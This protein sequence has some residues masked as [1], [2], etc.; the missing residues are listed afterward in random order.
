ME[1]S[2]DLR[3][4]GVQVKDAP[5]REHRDGACFRHV[6]ANAEKRADDQQKSRPSN[7]SPSII[8]LQ[9]SGRCRGLE[10]VAQ[11][12]VGTVVISGTCAPT[13]SKAGCRAPVHYSCYTRSTRVVKAE[14]GVLFINITASSPR[15]FGILARLALHRASR[16]QP[17][18]ST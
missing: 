14:S 1:S 12:T 13:L 16:R 4:N 9:R 7:Q 2:G 15:N 5:P 10:A 6:A 3:P 8:L 17:R 11:R 18:S